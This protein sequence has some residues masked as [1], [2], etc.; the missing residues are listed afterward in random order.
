MTDDLLTEKEHQ[1]VEVSAQLSRLM[2]EIIF[3]GGDP[4]VAASDRAEAITL[5][6]GI[7]QMILTQAA[8]RAYPDRYRLLGASLK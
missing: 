7:Q 6:H 8:A 3:E 1:A 4:G 5:I 2:A